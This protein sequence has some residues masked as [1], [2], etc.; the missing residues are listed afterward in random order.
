MKRKERIRY[1]SYEF[2][3]W[4]YIFGVEPAQHIESFRVLAKQNNIKVQISE[5]GILG[6]AES[7][8]MLQSLLA[9]SVLYN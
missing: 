9:R 2:I 8:V 3:A 7:L 6:S 1:V 5:L 4:N